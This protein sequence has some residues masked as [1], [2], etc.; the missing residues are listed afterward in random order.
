MYCPSSVRPQGITVKQTSGSN[1]RGKKVPGIW[2]AKRKIAT[3]VSR[4]I[5]NVTSMATSHQTRQ[6]SLLRL[7][8]LADTLT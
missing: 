6:S 4:G 1:T 8:V 2:M 3:R 7:H 5:R